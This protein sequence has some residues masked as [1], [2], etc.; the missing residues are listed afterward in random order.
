MA[1]RITMYNNVKYESNVEKFPDIFDSLVQDRNALKNYIHNTK[2]SLLSDID[3]E[4]KQKIM[5]N[6]YEN[7]NIDTE[8]KKRLE[9]IQ[10]KIQFILL[11]DHKIITEESFTIKETSNRYLPD[12]IQKYIEA[13]PENPE[14]AKALLQEQLTLIEKKY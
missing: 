11:S 2:M 8:T 1:N 12:A 9:E 6:T 4:T 5:S 13:K 7:T 14:K 3:E 10:E